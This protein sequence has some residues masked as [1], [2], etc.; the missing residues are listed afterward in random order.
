M[1]FIKIHYFSNRKCCAERDQDERFKIVV[2][3]FF[4]IRIDNRVHKVDTFSSEF[5]Y[6][7]N[8]NFIIF[9]IILQLSSRVK[10]LVFFFFF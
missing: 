4:E 2:F 1:I 6:D 9:I 3:F 10:F 8:V 5:Y 7:I